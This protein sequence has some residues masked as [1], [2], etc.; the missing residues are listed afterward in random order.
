MRMFDRKHAYCRPAIIRIHFWCNDRGPKQEKEAQKRRNVLGPGQPP[1]K[2]HEKGNKEG[3]PLYF[4]YVFT[5]LRKDLISAS[6]SIS[7]FVINVS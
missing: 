2:I 7:S 6:L 1:L 5:I 3:N 4:I